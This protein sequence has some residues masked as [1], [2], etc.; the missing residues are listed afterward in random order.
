MSIRLRFILLYAGAFLLFCVW[1]TAYYL[2]GRGGGDM[3]RVSQ[4][5]V[6][7]AAAALAS[8]LMVLFL[9]REI[10]R[11]AREC[12]HQK[13]DL[14]QARQRAALHREQTALGMIEWDAS[15]RITAWNAAAEAI[16]GFSEG[17]V[18]GRDLLD[19]VV[20]D[21]DLDRAGCRS[22]E[23]AAN[24]ICCVV[25]ENRT[26]DGRTILCEWYYTPVAGEGGGESRTVA[27][28]RDVTEQKRVENQL[29]RQKSFLRNVI[30]TDPNLVFVK[31][32]AGVFT[33]ANRALAEAYGTTVEDVEGKTDADFHSDPEAVQAFREADLQTLASREETFVLQEPLVGADGT[34]RWLQTV[35]R[36][37]LSPNGDGYQVLGI[38]VDITARRQ[39]EEQLRHLMNSA[40]CLLWSAEVCIPELA[41]VPPAEGANLVWKF[42]FYDD[43]AAQRFLPLEVPP[44]K[45]YADAAYD[46]RHPGDR[47]RTDRFS[48]EKIRAGENYSQEFRVQD[49]S[50]KWRWLREDVHVVALGPGRWQAV[51][52]AMEI[53]EQKQSEEQ[54]RHLM[55]GARCLLWSAETTLTDGTGEGRLSWRFVHFDEEAAQRFLP[56]RILPGRTYTDSLAWNGIPEEREKMNEH[57]TAMILAGKDYTQEYRAWGADGQWH[58]LREDVR[59]SEI[60]PGCWRL[61]AVVTDVT[62]LKVAQNKAEEA[63]AA[64]E[65]AARLKSEFLANMSHEIRTPM[66]GVIGMTGLLLDT[67]LT[68]EQRDYAETVRKSA[69]SLLTVIN[70]ILDFSKL[71]AGKLTIEVEDFNLRLLIEEV[72]T[73]LA[74][75]AHEKGLEALLMMI[76]PDFPELVRGDAGRLRQILT[77]L[78]GNAIKFTEQ[79][80]VT[81]ECELLEAGPE[82]LRVWIEV[83]DTGIGISEEGQACLFQ[84]FSQ[85]D[86]SSTRKYGGTG[87]GLAICK[88]LV[89][90]MGGHIGVNSQLGEGS[91]FWFDLV[92]ERQAQPVTVG[93]QSDSDKDGQPNG[94]CAI[95]LRTA[96][97]RKSPALPA[98]LQGLRVLVVDDNATNRLILRQQLRAWGCQPEEVASGEE[99]LAALR[100]TLPDPAASEEA[101]PGF[102]LVLMDMQ[103]PKMDGEATA[104]GIR[105]LDRLA[106]L[107]L[108][109]LTSGAA[110]PTQEEARE[111]GF[112]GV[113]PK[114]VRQD[115][116]AELITTVMAEARTPDGA[117]APALSVS[118]APVTDVTSPAGGDARPYILLAEDN[119][120]NQKL[121]KRLLEKWGYAVDVAAN[122]VEAIALLEAADAGGGGYAAVLMDVQMP[123]MD[124]LEATAALRA[125]EAR[126][127]GRRLPVIAMTAHA[128][129]GD[130]ERCLAAGMDDYISKPI[131]AQ[132]LREMLEHWRTAGEEGTPA[133][134]LAA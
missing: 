105:S 111:M 23:P 104:R 52:A 109:L 129:E 102:D 46:S 115:H 60:T 103:M 127:G 90:L 32:E 76:S 84:S 3:G 119:L 97:F 124:G 89:E 2:N 67:D 53:T 49:Q 13:S 42:L 82:L 50:G 122:G 79:G 108:I 31:D 11:L 85:V 35:K 80:E 92:L 44:G 88:Q 40:R 130:R 91:T 74:P 38:A 116:L 25:N 65:A 94:V 73:L 22:A 21:G 70:D 113:L 71:E 125:R 123:E 56:L 100:R 30:D 17:E 39:A 36:P 114:P 120:V 9:V 27:L 29:L 64:A 1:L 54:R 95:D 41:D 55:N 118:D 99:A 69:D 132:N 75:R 47:E 78:V 8:V 15:R 51:G 126:T 93:P 98:F 57:A 63:Q 7:L 33:L 26:R 106:D 37:I 45:T 110:A 131:A 134:L 112:V 24:G 16:F 48:D 68:E 117:N 20:P 58:W 43:S 5:G 10:A 18:L 59:V 14:E 133:R 19:L 28:V 107:P 128:L 6:F 86:G 61:A 34:V 96:P 101:G 121:T 4:S 62:D 87:L 12:A 77:N 83:R 66:N 72:L 81:V